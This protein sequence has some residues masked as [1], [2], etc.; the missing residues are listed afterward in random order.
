MKVHIGL[1]GLPYEVELRFWL[2]CKLL[3]SSSM[4]VQLNK[5][6]GKPCDILV[7]DLDSEQGQIAYEMAIH[8]DAR[9]IFLSNEPHSEEPAGT[10]IDKH[11]TASAIAKT[12]ENVI[13]AAPRSTRAAVNGLLGICLLQ[14]GNGHEVLASNGRI[15]V[16]LRDNG[17]RLYASCR[18][19]LDSAKQHLLD[20]A[21]AS[22]PVTAPCE[23]Q[24]E[25]LVCETLDS[26]L[27]SACL[28]HRDSL[29]MISDATY[30]LSVWPDFIAFPD[31][32][33]AVRLSSA[34]Y[35]KSWRVADL[36]EHCG[37]SVAVANAFCWAMQAS[38]A[39]RLDDS[40]EAPRV[41]PASESLPLVQRMVRSFGLK[42]RQTHA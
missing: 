9:V 35:R 20:D 13:L 3:M 39:L 27:V 12:L 28:R 30:R 17:R 11:A 21:W 38:G 34:L 29:P 1:A 7:A 10:R 4:S 6:D 14:G 26:F 25:G 31:N 33:E 15:S 16:I 42:A 36:A 41:E 2:A 24:Y 8:G 32:R 37:V 40:V 19:E 23:H 5:W 18:E 22:V